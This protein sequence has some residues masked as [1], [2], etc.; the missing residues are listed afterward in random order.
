MNPPQIELIDI[1]IGVVTAIV[2]LAVSSFI[3]FLLAK[4]YG[5]LAGTKAAIDFEKEKAEQARITTIKSL[6]NEVDRI[7]TFTDHNSTL[8]RDS[9]KVQGVV[10]MPVAVLET[11]FLSGDSSL[12]INSSVDFDGTPVDPAT[13]GIYLRAEPLASATDYLAEAYSI[14]TLIDIYLGLVRGLSS[15]EQAQRG[16]AINGIIDKS[17]ALYQPLARLEKYLNRE[18]TGEKYTAADFFNDQLGDQV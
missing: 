17:K 1:L 8:A 12:S 11:A 13:P 2:T 15:Q 7:R 14:N 4:K 3:S 9:Q 6:L 18:L 10:R 5:D 16:E